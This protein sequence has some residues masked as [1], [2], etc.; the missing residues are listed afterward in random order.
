MRGGAY[1]FRTD[2]KN[3]AQNNLTVEILKPFAKIADEIV[4]SSEDPKNFAQYAVAVGLA[5]RKRGDV[6]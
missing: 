5:T 1:P 2:K 4:L 3:A 6:K